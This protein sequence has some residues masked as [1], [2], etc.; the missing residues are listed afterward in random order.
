M[1]HNIKIRSHFLSDV[2]KCKPF[3]VPIVLNTDGTVEPSRGYVTFSRWD[4]RRN[5]ARETIF[6]PPPRGA[7]RL[8]ARRPLV[9]L[10][11]ARH[12]RELFQRRARGVVHHQIVVL[13]LGAERCWSAAW[14]AWQERAGAR[15]QKE[16]VAEH[17]RGEGAIA[18]QQRAESE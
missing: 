16:E 4:F 5:R 18:E 9:G 14:P 15:R 10:A 12:E 3:G 8:R 6:A 1:L 13:R 2:I 17:R 11:R 7:R